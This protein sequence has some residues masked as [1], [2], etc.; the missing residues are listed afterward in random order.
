MH[1]FIAKEAHYFMSLKEDYQKHT[2]DIHKLSLAVT[3]V[4]T[5]H[6]QYTVYS[7]LESEG[8]RGIQ[9]KRKESR[10]ELRTALAES[11]QLLENLIK[12]YPIGLFP[13]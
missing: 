13:K 11:E 7:L 12:N 9:V 2:E 4:A 8:K 10:E 1:I 6:A 3:K 5:Y